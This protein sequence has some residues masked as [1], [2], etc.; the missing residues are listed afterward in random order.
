V[1]FRRVLLASAAA[2]IVLGLVGCNG[3]D[4]GGRS[5]EI[6]GTGYSVGMPDGWH[7]RTEEAR[8][9]A[10]NFDLFL[11]GEREGGFITSV[12]VIREAPPGVPDDVDELVETFTR[13]LGV[14]GETPPQPLPKRE[15]DGEPARGNTVEVQGPQARYTVVQYFTIHDDA[16][17]TVT[18]GAHET[19]L[20]EARADFSDLLDSWRWE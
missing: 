16:V 12:N 18:L 7:D 11:A 6:S 2:C 14:L 8:S 15:I 1:D 17:Y 10:I 4:G 3:G 19:A 9:G 20:S 5:N 13:Q